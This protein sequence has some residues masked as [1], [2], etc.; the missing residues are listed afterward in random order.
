MKRYIELF[1]KING[2][3]EILSFGLYNTHKQVDEKVTKLLASKIIEPISDKE[4]VTRKIIWL[5]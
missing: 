1:A 4:T 2:R 3:N 5:D